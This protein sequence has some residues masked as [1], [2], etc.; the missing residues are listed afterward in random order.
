MSKIVNNM[1]LV[2]RGMNEIAALPP[3]WKGLYKRRSLRGYLDVCRERAR[4]DSDGMIDWKEMFKQSF[5]L[6]NSW[7]RGRITRKTKFSGHYT[8]VIFVDFINESEM[9]SVASCGELKAW[10][11]SR[12]NCLRHVRYDTSHLGGFRKWSCVK[13]VGEKLYALPEWS[14]R[15]D[16]YSVYSGSLLHSLDDLNSEVVSFDVNE[17]YIAAGLRDGVIKLFSTGSCALIWSSVKSGSMFSKSTKTRVDCVCFDEQEDDFYVGRAS[18]LERWQKTG[19]KGG[20]K[21][22]KTA[23]ARYEFG[24]CGY[25][26]KASQ[27]GVFTSDERGNILCFDK[28]LSGLRGKVEGH[29][30]SKVSS[31]YLKAGKLATCSAE[32]MTLKIWTHSPSNG[33]VFLFE[34]P[35]SENALAQKIGKGPPRSCAFNL[36]AI[37]CGTGDAFLKMWGV[38]LL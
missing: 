4:A 33:L 19:C 7:A 10:D 12:K 36:K 14:K 15:I 26:M 2:S 31:M 20:F 3:V 16:V 5:L 34:V 1:A 38:G 30:G 25:E 29:G 11:V 17:N 8:E 28:S 35:V 21:F 24:D 18:C 22:K 32:D 6:D 9:I 37:V 23:K 27:D 13:V